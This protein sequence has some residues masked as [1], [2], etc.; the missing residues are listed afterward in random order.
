MSHFSVFIRSASQL[1]S[2]CSQICVT[3]RSSRNLQGGRGTCSQ[4][5]CDFAQTSAQVRASITIHL[6]RRRTRR[7]NYFTDHH[8]SSDT[9]VQH[10]IA[11]S[12]SLS[13]SSEATD[14]EVVECPGRIRNQVPGCPMTASSC[15]LQLASSHLSPSHQARWTHTCPKSSPEMLSGSRSKRS[16]G[17]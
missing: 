16:M 12:L 8:C 1:Q 2:I 5:P 9:R 14:A 17:R 4:R 3:S 11:L 10:M 6:L 7:A 15:Y 13:A